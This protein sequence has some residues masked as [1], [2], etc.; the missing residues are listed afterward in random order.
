MGP[1]TIRSKTTQLESAVGPM[2]IACFRYSEAVIGG[3]P[4]GVNKRPSTDGPGFFLLTVRYWEK[5][6]TPPGQEL[7]VICLDCPPGSGHR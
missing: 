5:Y 2:D 4:D 1:A 7:T 6:Q 3:R